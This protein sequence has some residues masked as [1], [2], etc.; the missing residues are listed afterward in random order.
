MNAEIDIIK[1]FREKLGLT[2]LELAK[3]LGYTS[4][5][6]V[7]KWE[8]GLIDI[9]TPVL[10]LIKLLTKT[11]KEKALEIVKKGMYLWS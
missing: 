4:Y 8:L 10:I 2:Q 9:P 1:G 5:T 3:F 11:K 7:Q 6:T